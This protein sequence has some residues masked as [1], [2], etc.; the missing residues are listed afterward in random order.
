MDDSAAGNSPCGCIFP[1]F[2]ISIFIFPIEMVP[3]VPVN[4]AGA[5][6]A[7]SSSHSAVDAT[8]RHIFRAPAE[9]AAVV[10]AQVIADQE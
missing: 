4:P 3:L 7:G 8:H 9:D 2:G 5:A 1:A 6:A 10:W